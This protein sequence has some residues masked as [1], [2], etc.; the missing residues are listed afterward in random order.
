[1]TAA[2]FLKF[3]TSEM[4]EQKIQDVF[5]ATLSQSESNTWYDFRY[6][7]ITASVAYEATKCKKA[8]GSL[9]KRIIGIGCRL[10][11]EAMKRGH[12][13]EDLI[14]ECMKTKY[15][16]LRKCGL[17]LSSKYPELGASADGICDD[18][19][20]EIKAPMKNLNIANYMKD[21][22]PT[23]RY[24]AQVILQMLMCGKKKAMFVVAKEEFENNQT[25]DNL[26]I[27]H[28]DFD[29]KK[30]FKLAHE[31]RQ[32][33]IRSIFPKMRELNNMLH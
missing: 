33:W 27:C 5:K 18:F 24:E 4:S 12:T 17:Q 8:D 19:V 23:P 1:M 30:A 11:T 7:R 26:V 9:V 20:L 2:H 31:C 13:M 28:V 14:F 21:S 3:C 29:E 16:R 25:F 22:K 6:G 32:F 10:T 15:P